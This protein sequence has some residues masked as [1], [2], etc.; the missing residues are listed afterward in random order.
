MRTYTKNGF[1]PLLA[2]L[3]TALDELDNTWQPD[4][5]A[6]HADVY[7]QTMMSLSYSYFAYFHAT[8]E[9][10]DWAPLWNPVF[11][12][13]PNPDDIYLYSP[14][15]GKYC[16]RVSGKRGTVKILSFTTQRHMS[17]MIDDISQIGGHN[18][19]DDSDFS[20][21]EHGNIDILFSVEKP[22]G[23]AGDWAPIDPE[24]TGMMVRLRSYD[25]LNEI[26][27]KLAI[28]CLDPVGP[29]PRL[30]PSAIRDRIKEM[31]KFPGRKT[32]SYYRLQNG[33]K[34]RVGF[35]VFEP[36]RMQGALASIGRRA[37]S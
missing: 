32:K 25:W 21:D 24:A 29:K 8:P 16:Y 13:Q 23:Y 28:T 4:D 11:T 36:I 27:P 18:E 3:Q 12:L 37:S 14:I 10:P 6:Y 33:V 15:S 22:S 2:D 17:G 30:T 26:D 9:H 1:F 35:N 31:A 19:I 5:E 7:R 20:V 34:D